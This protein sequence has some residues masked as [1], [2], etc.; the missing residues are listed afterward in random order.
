MDHEAEQSS[1]HSALTTELVSACL[2]AKALQPVALDVSAMSDIADNFIV[3][4]GR[5]DRH[6]IGIANRAI[7]AAAERGISPSTIEGL[8]KGHWVLLDFGDVV[9]HVF[10]E[11]L[12]A[13]YNLENLWAEARRIDLRQIGAAA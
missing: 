2:E 6:V 7:D 4:S 11:P 5:S 13:H 1:E 3:V 10:Y 12:R 8:E 9:L